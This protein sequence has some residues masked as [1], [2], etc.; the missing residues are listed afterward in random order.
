MCHNFTLDCV[1][2]F[3]RKKKIIL[4]VEDKAF[5]TSCGFKQRHCNVVKYF[6][7]L[8]F[9]HLTVLMYFFMKIQVMM[10]RKLMKFHIHPYHGLA[11]PRQELAFTARQK[12]QSQSQ[13]FRY[14]RSIFRFPIGPFFQISLIY[15]FI[16]CP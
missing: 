14:S 16:G 13:I 4:M 5:S 10:L 12:I 9:Y 2:Q 15:A 3:E 11:T 8:H 1:T 7:K 6:Q